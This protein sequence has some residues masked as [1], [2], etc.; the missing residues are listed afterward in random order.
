MNLLE[1]VEKWILYF[2]FGIV[3]LEC[4]N[5]IIMIIELNKLM[6][7]LYIVNFKNIVCVCVFI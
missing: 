6:F 2:N 7:G 3:F 4:K 5:L 1:I